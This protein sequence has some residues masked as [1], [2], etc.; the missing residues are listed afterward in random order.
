MGYAT[1]DRVENVSLMSIGNHGYDNDA[2]SMRAVF[3]SQRPFA[4]SEGA[5]RKPR[6]GGMCFRRF[7]TSSLTTSSCD[8][9]ASRNGH[10]RP[11]APRDFGI[12]G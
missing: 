8:G 1:T 11:T 2:Y 5:Q 12:D 4:E 3:I 7:R 10:Q 9:S 6:D